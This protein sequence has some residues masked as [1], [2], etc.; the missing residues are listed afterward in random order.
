MQRNQRMQER[1][2]GE[3]RRGTDEISHGG[4][5]DDG[6][7][8]ILELEGKRN[9][10]K[11]RG[12]FVDECQAAGAVGQIEFVG[13]ADFVFG[14]LRGLESAVGDFS[15]GPVQIGLVV[16]DPRAECFQRVGGVV[17]SHPHAHFPSVA[18]LANFVDRHS[19]AGP[20][21]LDFLGVF[22]AA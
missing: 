12:R 21:L 6:R 17:E 10:R 14:L 15:L 3:P 5:F 16:V 4:V 8:K 19:D 9:A 11:H 2:R 20:M 18:I 13:D 22:Q 7:G 1:F